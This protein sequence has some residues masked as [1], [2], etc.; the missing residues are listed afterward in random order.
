VKIDATTVKRVYDF[1]QTHPQLAGNIFKASEEVMNILQATHG[2]GEVDE[3][4]VHSQLHD[5]ILEAERRKALA[6]G[7]DGEKESPAL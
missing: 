7:T 5:I 2:Y 6:E 1:V 3:A 4:A